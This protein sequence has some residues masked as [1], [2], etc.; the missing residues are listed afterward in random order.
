MQEVWRRDEVSVGEVKE[1]L[2]ACAPKDRAYTTYMTVMARLDSKGLLE[3]TRSGKTDF[4]RPLYSRERYRELRARAAVD[5]LVDQ[6]GDVALAHRSPDGSV[7]AG[8]PSISPAP[9]SQGVTTDTGTC[10][11]WRW[12]FAPAV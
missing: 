11:R 1:A 2:N 9:C 3:R 6:F 5:S 4:Y 8:T 7:G 10:S 12:C